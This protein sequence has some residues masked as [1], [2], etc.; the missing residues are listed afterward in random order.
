MSDDFDFL[1]GEWAVTNRRLVEWQAGGEEWEEFPATATGR[2]FFGGAGSFDEIVFHTKGFSGSAFR[3]FNPRTENWA[4]YWADSRYGSVDPP[5]VGRFTGGR[6]EFYGE[7][8]V[9]GRPVKVRFIWSQITPVSAKWEQAFSVD[10]GRTW[11]TNWI[12]E[13]SRRA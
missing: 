8:T 3:V 7:D 9:D 10:D 6:G 12:M 4:I 5:M 13:F 1:H 11:E 2:G